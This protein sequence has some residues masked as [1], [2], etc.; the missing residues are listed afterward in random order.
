MTL[1]L[2]RQDK[3]IVQVNSSSY[4]LIKRCIFA[5]FLQW[6]TSPNELVRYN[7][8]QLTLSEVCA[9]NSDKVYSLN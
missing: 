7:E 9:N 2:A 4:R 6:R 5:V 3:I 8:G 1:R